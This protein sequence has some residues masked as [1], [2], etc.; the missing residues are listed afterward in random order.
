[1]SAAETAKKYI[2]ENAVMVFSKSYCP[3]VSLR[4]PPPAPL[5]LV[6][7][8]TLFCAAAGLCPV[9]LLQCKKAKQALTDEGAKWTAIELDQRDDGADIQAALLAMT[10][11]RT[12]PNIFIKREHIGGCDDTLALIKSGQLKTKL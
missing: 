9:R 7:P 4:A 8:L 1:M 3:Y 10:G 11:Q 2:D 6:R 12:V 5:S